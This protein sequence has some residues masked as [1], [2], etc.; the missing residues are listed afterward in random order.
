MTDDTRPL[1]AEDWLRDIAAN[2]L[3]MGV[4]LR[5]GGHGD[6]MPEDIALVLAA[7]DSTRQAL[8]SERARYAALEKA[9]DEIIATDYDD[10]ITEWRAL[11]KARA[12]LD[13]EPR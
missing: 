5:D 4:S 3:T 2:G 10:T 11:A 9:V 7:L 1:S 13:G 6:L 12:A 8:D